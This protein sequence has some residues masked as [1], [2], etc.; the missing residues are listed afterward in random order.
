MNYW[1]SLDRCLSIILVQPEF[2]FL[3]KSGLY[4]SYP[5]KEYP[6]RSTYVMSDHETEKARY[7]IPCMDLPTVRTTLS[8]FITTA[9]DK[10]A[11]ANGSLIEER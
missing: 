11:L 10:V 7:W 3:L 4:F 9:K 5:T 2:P 1:D 6:E 8:F